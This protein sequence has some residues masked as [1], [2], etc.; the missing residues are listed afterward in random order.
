MFL[1]RAPGVVIISRLVHRDEFRSSGLSQVQR[2][3]TTSRH[4]SRMN[5]ARP[6]SFKGYLKFLTEQAVNMENPTVPFGCTSRR[7]SRAVLVILV[8]VHPQ[9][10]HRSS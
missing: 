8:M 4:L 3:R 6:D 2:R 7:T 9:G 10:A 1:C 5:L